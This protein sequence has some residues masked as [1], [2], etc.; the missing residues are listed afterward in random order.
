MP[1]EEI[2]Q[3][4]AITPLI[5]GITLSGGEPFLQPSAALYL[6]RQAHQHNLDVWIYSGYT[7]DKLLELQQPEIHN[8]L[9]YCDVLVDGPFR[10][11]QKRLDLPYRGSANQRLIAIPATQREKQIVL[12]DL[13]TG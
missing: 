13:A 11:E 5:R 7:Y 6:A 1:V 12:W 8:L 4:L 3:N 10:Q 2:W 9:E